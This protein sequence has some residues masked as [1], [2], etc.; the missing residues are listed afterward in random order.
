MPG[1]ADVPFAPAANL[2]CRCVAMA[3]LQRAPLLTGGAIWCTAHHNAPFV[4]H[5]AVLC[6]RECCHQTIRYFDELAE[7]QCHCS[8][9][10]QSAGN[11]LPKPPRTHAVNT[12]ATTH[13]TNYTLNPSHPGLQQSS[14]KS[15]TTCNDT[16]LIC[17]V[18]H[19][20]ALALHCTSRYCC[21]TWKHKALYP[22]NNQALKPLDLN[23]FSLAPRRAMPSCDL[24]KPMPSC[25]QRIP[26]PS[27]WCPSS[28]DIPCLPAIAAR[29]DRPLSAVGDV[30]SL[31]SRV[32]SASQVVPRSPGRDSTHP[33][34]RWAWPLISGFTFE[35][36]KEVQ[37]GYI[38]FHKYDY[39]MDNLSQAAR[40]CIWP[41]DRAL[42]FTELTNSCFSIFGHKTS[43]F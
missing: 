22:L 9:P 37:Q 30:R 42:N 4:F 8:Y 12:P 2:T 25:V 17:T 29:K 26:L 35:K 18:L 6:R 31:E 21:Q 33:G 13:N 23:A 15:T 11:M 40:K 14:R 27:P 5:A 24:R 7:S 38:L 43:K 3:Y 19:C 28:I 41:L 16:L 36:A 32:S 10:K 39:E 34:C 20:P 1:Q